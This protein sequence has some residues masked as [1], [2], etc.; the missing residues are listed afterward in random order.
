MKG[1]RFMEA[2]FGGGSPEFDRDDLSEMNNRDIHADL[3]R[4]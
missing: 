2:S 4:G 1:N 3:G